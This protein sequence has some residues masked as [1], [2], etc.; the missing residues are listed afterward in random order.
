ME[1][2]VCLS[3]EY[4]RH[5]LKRLEMFRGNLGVTCTVVLVIRRRAFES[6]TVRTQKGSQ[7]FGNVL[8]VF[9]FFYK[10]LIASSSECILKVSFTCKCIQRKNLLSQTILGYINIGSFSGTHFIM[11]FYFYFILDVV[12]ALLAQSNI[13]LNQQVSIL[14]YFVAFYFQ[15][16][17]K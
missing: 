11:S 12:E 14:I 6:V 15:A 10:H 17:R 7:I 5:S 2:G 16:V 3:N 4:T 13:E 1:V 8:T 9:F